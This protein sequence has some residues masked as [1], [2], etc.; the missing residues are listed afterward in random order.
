[1]GRSPQRRTRLRRAEESAS[2]N[3]FEDLAR[4]IR[5]PLISG[6]SFWILEESHQLLL[7]CACS[8]ESLYSGSEG[9]QFDI[10]VVLGQ[11]DVRSEGTRLIFVWKEEGSAGPEENP[12]LGSH[13]SPDRRLRLSPARSELHWERRKSDSRKLRFPRFRLPVC[14]WGH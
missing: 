4:S 10:V 1:M 9:V 5:L 11:E 2:I 12:E 6:R 7:R 13:Y 8:P 14:C 3:Q